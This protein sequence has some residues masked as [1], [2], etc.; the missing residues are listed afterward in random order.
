MNN[1]QKQKWLDKLL[2]SETCLEN[3]YDEII[4]NYRKSNNKTK[5]LMVETIEYL[6]CCLDDIGVAKEAIQQQKGE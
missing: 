5:N 3:L 1:E 2:E 6:K 4:A